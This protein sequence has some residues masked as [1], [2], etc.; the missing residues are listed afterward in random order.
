MSQFQI[1]PPCF[2][3]FY[4]NCTPFD[5]IFAGASSILVHHVGTMMVP[6]GGSPSPGGAPGGAPGAPGGAPGM[7]GMPQ[8][9]GRG[10]RDDHFLGK[11]WS[12]GVHKHIIIWLIEI[13]WWFSNLLS[14]KI[15]VFLFNGSSGLDDNCGVVQFW[16]SQRGCEPRGLHQPAVLWAYTQDI[17]RWADVKSLGY[18]WPTKFVMFYC[19]LFSSI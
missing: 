5:L 14:S 10:G 13:N 9:T 3:R 4:S 6:S 19:V 1:C 11:K 8:M 7:P 12:H 15:V 2:W 16:K 17:P 18:Q